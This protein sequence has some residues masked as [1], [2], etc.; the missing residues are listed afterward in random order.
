MGELEVLEELA[1]GKVFSSCSCEALVI[2]AQGFGGEG[3][4]E[5]NVTTSESRAAPSL[6]LL[7]CVGIGG[8]EGGGGGGAGEFSV[9]LMAYLSLEGSKSY[10][11]LLCKHIVLLAV[12]RAIAS[13]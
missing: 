12:C 4:G 13:L 3:G 10:L 8:G 11:S 6:K 5:K 9:V 7:S 1:V 2:S